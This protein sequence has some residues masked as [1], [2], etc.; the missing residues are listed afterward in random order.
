M[1][2]ASGVQV[3]GELYGL[4]AA[5]IRLARALAKGASLSDVAAELGLSK[6]TLRAQ[7]AAI[8]D[9]TGTSRQSDLVRL[10]VTQSAPAR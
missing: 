9:K 10:L 8:S 4:S 5:E 2:G 7:L 6:E 3:V 1:P